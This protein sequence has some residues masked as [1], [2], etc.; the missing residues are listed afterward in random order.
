[1]LPGGDYALVNIR[2]GGGAVDDDHIGVISVDDGRIED[3]GLLGTNA[4]YSGTGHIVFGRTTNE[5]FAVPFSLGSRKVLGQPERIL[6]G[7]WTGPAGAV[8]VAVS[9]NGTL[10]YHDGDLGGQRALWVVRDDG[11]EH[12]VVAP[13]R[14]YFAPRVSP[15][16]MHVLAETNVAG[17]FT[18][19][20]AILLVDLRN[21]AVQQIASAGEGLSPEWSRDGKRVV[22][23]KFLGS[24]GREIISRAWDGSGPD[25]LLF[26]DANAVLFD[27]RLGNTGEWSVLRTGGVGAAVRARDLLLAPTD[28]LS[29]WRPFVSTPANEITPAISPDGRWLAYVSDESGRDEVYVQPIP[30]PGPRVQASFAGGKEP[31]WSPRGGTLFYRSASQHV[32]AARLLTSPLRVAKWDTLFSDRFQRNGSAVTNW[33]VFPSGR[34]FL[35]LGDAKSTGNVKVLVNWPQRRASTRSASEAR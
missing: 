15:N 27:F 33:S 8:G 3:L 35:L 17:R 19:D 2:K 18:P 28:S 31:L 9:Q 34:E 29:K 11:T 14:Q 21:G 25:Q 16:G 1:M 23:L 13:V 20:S 5:V 24:K 12:R 30:G 22:F 26:H 4:Q 10:T 32:I 7:V 6:E